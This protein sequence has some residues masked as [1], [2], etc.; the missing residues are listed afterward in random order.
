MKPHNPEPRYETGRPPKAHEQW[1][2]S[3]E[4]SE[5]Q[6]E[7]K[8]TCYLCDGDHHTRDCS[9][10]KQLSAILSS[11]KTDED[12]RIGTLHIL[13]AVKAKRADKGETSGA[14]SAEKSKPRKTLKYVDVG[15]N[16]LSFKAFIDNGANLCLVAEKLAMQLGL[17]LSKEPGWIKVVDQPSRP[18]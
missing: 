8:W 13:N 15:I 9:Q 4:C 5:K 16:G 14:K 11:Y 7:R 12:A 10:R 6:R 3:A 2:G 17:V 18:I 1:R